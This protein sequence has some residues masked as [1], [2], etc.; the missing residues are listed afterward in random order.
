MEKEKIGKFISEVRK[1]KGLTQKELA[2]KIYISD[3]AVSKW[4]RGLSFP[5]I[6]LLEDLASVLDVSIVEL[7][8]GEKLKKLESET[9]NLIIDTI[10]LTK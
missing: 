5:D 10:E 6:E 7:L 2:R 3:K 9:E 8:K 4:E 1:E